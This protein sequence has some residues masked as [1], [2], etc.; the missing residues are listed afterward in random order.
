MKPIITTNAVKL[1]RI[2]LLV[3]I[4]V[5]IWFIFSPDLLPASFVEVEMFND[6][7]LYETLDNIIV[8]LVHL[9]SFLCIALWWPT[10]T[11]SWAFLF[12]TGTI[13]GLCSF[14]GP[15]MLSAIDGMLVTVF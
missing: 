5:A 1:F 4:F 8:P 3:Q 13:I 10:R 9:Q 14:S 7:P 15:S 6:R 2:T 12:V 11:T